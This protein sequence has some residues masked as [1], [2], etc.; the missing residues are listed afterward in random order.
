MKNKI[1][2]IFLT[3]SFIATPL[4][5]QETLTL[6]QAYQSAL[7]VSETIG[8]KKEIVEEAQGHFYQAMNVLMPDVEFVMTRMEQDVEKNS[9]SSGSSSLTGN[10]LRRTTPLNKFTI[11]QPLFSGFKEFAAIAGAGALKAQRRF[12]RQR[13]EELLWVD[14]SDSYYTLLQ[15]QK[16]LEVLDAIHKAMEDRIGELKERVNSG[17]SRSSE[18]QSAIADMKLVEADRIEAERAKK[19]AQSLFEF[20]IGRPL[21]EELEDGSS[22]M[23]SKDGQDVTSYITGYDQR[24]DVKAVEEA[25]HLA[26]K[27]VI[28]ARAGFLPSASLDANLYTKRVG[29]QSGID[30]DTTLTLNVPIFDGMQTVGD[31]KVAAAL[32]QQAY[33]ELSKTKREAQREIQDAFEN[34]YS[35]IRSEAALAQAA[36]AAEQDMKSQM[37]E[38]RS[39]LV[40]NLD[41]LDALR[42]FQEV[43]R[44]YT[45]ARYEMFKDYWRLKV[46]SGQ[47]WD[48][49]KNK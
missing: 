46:M 40:N 23:Y 26:E 44:R 13:A 48:K 5:A 35:S 12:E 34:F 31:V 2:F 3:I 47:L 17:R 27:N 9:S 37:D 1:T 4:F 24:S 16:N 8:Q 30:W 20:Y 36:D 18:V 21:T 6:E 33:L 38:Y 29:F 45:G 15:T 22:E 14:V 32:K 39:S 19:I 7:K 25:F 42:K 28:V 43:K 49:E 41:V 10:S 11:S